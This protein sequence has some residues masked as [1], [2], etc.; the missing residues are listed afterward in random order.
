M[1]LRIA[2]E[3]CEAV[4]VRAGCR[5]AG[6]AFLEAL[7]ELPVAQLGFHDH[8]QPIRKIGKGASAAVF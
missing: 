4:R 2:V 5:E 7:L 3:G 8:F 1:T 6:K